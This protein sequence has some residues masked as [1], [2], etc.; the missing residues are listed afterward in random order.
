MHRE[1]LS[2]KNSS[3]KGKVD[4]SGANVAEKE[5]GKIDEKDEG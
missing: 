4:P 3:S 5:V 2:K 1:G